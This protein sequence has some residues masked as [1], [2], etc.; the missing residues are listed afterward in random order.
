MI[1]SHLS[2]PDCE[3][4]TMSTLTI[5]RLVKSVEEIVPPLPVLLEKFK[6]ARVDIRK[7]RTELE[8]VLANGVEARTFADQNA[9]MPAL[10]DKL[11]AVLQNAERALSAR[12]APAE[13]TAEFALLKQ[14]AEAL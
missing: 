12:E 1:C 2:S 7:A 6:A 14:E 13:I 10:M 4:L 8:K 3:D 11:L 9:E 5:E